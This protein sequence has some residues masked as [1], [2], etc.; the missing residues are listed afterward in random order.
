MG[1]CGFSGAGKT[2]LIEALIPRYTARGLTVAVVKHDAHGLTLDRPGKDSDRFFEAGATVVVHDPRQIVRRSR[3]A[4]RADVLADALADLLRDHDLVLVEGHKETA[5]PV[6]LWLAAADSGPPPPE[7]GDFAAVL[8]RDGARLAQ[9]MA[10]ID[11]HLKSC[12]AARPLFAG[13]LVGGRSRRMGR[14]KSLL[15]SAGRTWLETVHEALASHAAQVCLLGDGPVP[16]GMEGLPR[17]VDAPGYAGPLAGMVAAMRWQ[18]EAPWIFAACDMPLLDPAAVSWLLAQRAPG[19]WAVLPRRAGAKRAEP[20]C[21]WYD[22]RMLPILERCDRPQAA[23]NL[24]QVR[25]ADLPGELAPRWLGFNTLEQCDGH[26]EI[27][28]CPDAEPDPRQASAIG[29][30]RPVD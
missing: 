15:R 16:A 9:A 23:R 4:T 26:I 24:A 10:L 14:P 11:N 29:T 21:A 19:A 28:D 1:I 5:L 7:A 13:L 12:L 17:L 6:R 18:P 30:A 3:S 27:E 8:A 20:L 22:P 25:V 2:T